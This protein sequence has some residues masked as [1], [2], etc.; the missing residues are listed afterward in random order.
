M[1]IYRENELHDLDHCGFEISWITLFRL[2][3]MIYRTLSTR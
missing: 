1:T 3:T 2:G